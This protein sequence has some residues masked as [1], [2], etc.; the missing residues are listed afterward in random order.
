[1]NHQTPID[2]DWA[3]SQLRDF[4]ARAE[5]A[6]KVRKK[7]PD[8][9][10]RVKQKIPLLRDILLR[11]DPELAKFKTG[12]LALWDQALDAAHAGIGVIES[13]KEV[14]SRMGP[15]LN[16]GGIDDLHPL[17]VGSARLPFA[18]EDFNQSIN[19]ASENLLRTTQSRL[20]NRTATG[21]RFWQQTFS[22]DPPKPGSPRLRWPGDASDPDVKT[23]LDGL[24]YLSSGIQLAVRNPAVHDASSDLS[25]QETLERLHSLSLLANLIDHCEVQTV[26]E[27]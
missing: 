17:I 12:K 14:Y 22:A 10:A 24:R 20:K 8:A 25:R 11:L 6:K 19:S 2:Y 26:D 4:I 9:D 7:P 18:R 23:M 3:E 16:A 1:M 15:P 5:A 27:S 21:S 13:Q